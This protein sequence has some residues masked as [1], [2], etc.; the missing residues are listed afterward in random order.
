MKPKVRPLWHHN[1]EHLV[2]TPA[3]VRVLRV[4]L[5]RPIPSSANEISHLAGLTR[6]ATWTA[7]NELADS[8]AVLRTGTGRSVNHR[9]DTGHP[10]AKLLRD[11]FNLELRCLDEFYALIRQLVRE[12]QGTLAV[13]SI[14]PAAYNISKLDLIVVVENPIYLWNA[15]TLEIWLRRR[16]DQ[17]RLQL[18]V[19][20]LTAKQAQKQNIRP[21][22]ICGP[23]PEAL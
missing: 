1:L 16:A 2:G 19:T 12:T 18:T 11:L 4:L 14:E 6:Q 7:L 5:L 22:V 20:A 3:R 15:E 13:W 10:F 21:R 8:G 17:L 9:A 23:G